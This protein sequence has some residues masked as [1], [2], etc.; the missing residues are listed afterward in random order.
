VAC[1]TLAR[2]AQGAQPKRRFALVILDVLLPDGDGVELLSEIRASPMAGEHRRSCCC[3]PRPRCA[4]GFAAS[5]PAPMNIS[6]SPT[7]RAT[8]S[9]A[10]ASCVRHGDA[11]AGAAERPCWW[12]TTASPS[13]RCCATAIE[14]AGYGVITAVSGEEGL[15][16]AADRRPS[17]LVVDGELPG[18]DGPTVIRRIRLDAALRADSLPAADRVRGAAMPRSRRWRRAPTPSCARRGYRRHRGQARR[19]PAQRRRAF[20]RQKVRRACSRQRRSS[21]STT[22]RPTSRRSR[23]RCASDRL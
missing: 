1:A 23:T 7:T 9:R 11:A 6:A 19:H 5:P 14:A 20:G 8:S 13:A 4:T 2:G 16:L 18:I 17:A 22:A 15:R 21:P 12:S 3:R 10:P